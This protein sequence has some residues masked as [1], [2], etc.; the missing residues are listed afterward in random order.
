[1]RVAGGTVTGD[2][3]TLCLVAGTSVEATVYIHRSTVAIIVS[4]FT[5]TP[6]AMPSLVVR[7]GSLTLDSSRIRSTRA[8][9]S[10]HRTRMA[11]GEQVLQLRVPE[12]SAGAVC[13][14]EV[15]VTQP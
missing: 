15:A 4:A 10:V 1:M 9:A 6:D 11:R 2:G 13:L 5:P 12:D 14:N 7:L 8:E 3:H